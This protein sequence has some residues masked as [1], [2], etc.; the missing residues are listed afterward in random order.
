MLSRYSFSAP[1]FGSIAMR[2]SFRITSRS[3]FAAPALLSPSKASPPVSAPSP[4]TAIT[5][6]FSPLRAD[7]AAMP[8]AAEIEVEACPVPNAS[9]SLSLMLGKPLNPFSLRFVRNRSRRPVMILWA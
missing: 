6:R 5:S 1:T 2:L 3:V 4:I 8:S 9:Y 7:A